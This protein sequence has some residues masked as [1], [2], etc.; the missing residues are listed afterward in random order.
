MKRLMVMVTGLGLLLGAY[1]AAAETVAGLPL[2]VHRFDSG[3]IGQWSEICAY[4]TAVSIVPVIDIAKQQFEAMAMAGQLP[5]QQPYA[6]SIS[7]WTNPNAPQAPLPPPPSF[8]A[9]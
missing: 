5:H 7:E 8:N 6:P 9:G 1:A 2:H 4:G 3:A